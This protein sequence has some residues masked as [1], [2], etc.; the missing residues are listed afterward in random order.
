[1]EIALLEKCRQLPSVIEMLEFFELSD[2]F[3]IVMERLP[4][5]MDL[6]DFITTRGSLDEALARN[7]FKQ[8]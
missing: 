6:F 5:S 1:M 3:L 8:V 2:G 7:F 4:A